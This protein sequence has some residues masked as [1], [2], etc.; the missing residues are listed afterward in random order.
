MNVSTKP[1]C[2]R[3]PPTPRHYSPTPRTPRNSKPQQTRNSKTTA[4]SKTLN[5]D[6]PP[7]TSSNTQEEVK[8]VAAQRDRESRCNECNN[9]PD[10]CVCQAEVTE[11]NTQTPK[12][13][14]IIW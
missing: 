12:Q 5:Q 13:S 4:P 14:F 8:T 1:L 9:T 10:K 3:P 6:K 11:V 7:D 2:V